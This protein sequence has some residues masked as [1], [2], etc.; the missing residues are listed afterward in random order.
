MSISKAAAALLLALSAAACAKAAPQS[1]TPAAGQA[2]VRQADFRSVADSLVDF[3]L[4]EAHWGIE[5]WDQARNA[6]IYGHNHDKHFVPASNTKL[7]VTT[8]A[9]GLLGPD[10]RYRTP[11]MLAGAPGDSAPGALI[12]KGTGDPTWSGRYFGSDLAVLDSIADSLYVKGVRRIAGDIIIDATAFTR[13]RIHSSWEIGDLPWYY[14]APTSAFA[15]GEAA[16]RMVVAKN[17]V[18]FPAGFAPAP[19]VMRSVIDSAGSTNNIDV[20][21]SAW[22]DSLVVSGTLA[23][24]KADSSWVAI[25]I[26]ERY[27]AEALVRALRMK[28]IPVSGSIRI[29]YDRSELTQ[30]PA[31]HTALT[32]SSPPMKDIVAGILKPS[33][34]WIAE[35]VLKT[36]GYVKGEAGSWR[37]G[38]NV[39]RRYLID[40]VKIDSAAFSLTDASGLSAQNLLAPHAIVMLLEHART[41]AW[42]PQYRAALPV[43]GGSGTL[44]SRLSGLESRLA[45]KT[46]TIANVNSLSGYLTTADGRNLTFSIMTNAS[47]KSSALMRRGMD[48]LVQALAQ[49]RN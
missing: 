8:V 14:A 31:A 41:S 9:M 49:S 48:V 21:Y 45:A 46:G 11:I 40:V 1:P 30:L 32:W 23:I 39:E 27:A 7:V 44:S 38:V 25:P 47:G 13:D 43:P 20:D 33:Q 5:V 22:P 16:V 34:N 24:G 17:A 12:I 3:G 2:A 6:M 42:G 19:V 29:L 4:K 28:K 26:P 37:A 18:T 15:V 36:L 35:Q 10:W